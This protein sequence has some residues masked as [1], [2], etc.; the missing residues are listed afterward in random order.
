MTR[1][2][3]RKNILTTDTYEQGIGGL[4]KGQERPQRSSVWSDAHHDALRIGGST[5][6][7]DHLLLL[8]AP[9]TRG[10]CRASHTTHTSRKWSLPGAEANNE[11]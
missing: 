10:Q 2:H 6:E 4:V 5:A 9:H 8:V 7:R 1:H 3:P 11:D